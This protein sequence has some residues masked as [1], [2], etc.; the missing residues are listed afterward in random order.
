MP[1]DRKNEKKPLHRSAGVKF[2]LLLCRDAAVQKAT[3]GALLVVIAF[4]SLL[5]VQSGQVRR[6][7]ELHP[8]VYLRQPRAALPKM[9]VQGIVYDRTEPL[10]LINDVI[11]RA[12]DAMMPQAQVREI[13]STSIILDNEGKKVELKFPEE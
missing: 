5:R 6:L 1:S 11:V 3:I 12:G 13:T 10:A 4:F 7:Q 9:A 2:L 8:D